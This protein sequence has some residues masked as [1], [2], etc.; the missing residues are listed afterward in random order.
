MRM[1]WKILLALPAYHV[2]SSGCH[3]AEVNLNELISHAGKGGSA[4]SGSAQ[5]GSTQGGIGAI[6]PGGMHPSGDASDSEGGTATGGEWSHANNAGAD[7]GEKAGGAAGEAQGGA[8]GPGGA[9]GESGGVGGSR[10]VD[11]SGG[12]G[13]GDDPKDTTSPRVLSISP[14]DGEHGVGSDC[15]IVIRF[16]EPMNRE[17]AMLGVALGEIAVAKEWDELGTELSLRPFKQLEYATGDDHATVEAIAYSVSVSRSGTDV[18]GNP[19]DADYSATFYTLREFSRQ[20]RGNDALIGYAIDSGNPF[21]STGYSDPWVGDA[22]D[23]AMKGFVTFELSDL[24]PETRDVTSAL[25]TANQYQVN[26]NPFQM[27]GII[28]D[29]VTFSVVGE[30][31]TAPTKTNFRTLFPD[32]A[33][34]TASRDVTSAVRMELAERQNNAGQVQFRFGFAQA[35]EPNGVTDEVRLR[36]IELDVS[37]LVP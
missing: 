14:S 37:Y 33:T 19:L 4:Q 8:S 36:P 1:R 31:L 13:G 28:L 29:H 25:L 2:V 24:P 20:L 30:V 6:E 7:T 18:A 3:R 22:G 35:A 9:A 16:S 11:G 34:K 5:S 12:V 23:R 26:G 17:Q 21:D 15:T 10:E 32:A 27:G